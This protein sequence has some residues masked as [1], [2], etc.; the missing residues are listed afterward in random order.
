ME[1]K[2]SLFRPRSLL[3]LLLDTREFHS[4]LCLRW[5]QFERGADGDDGERRPSQI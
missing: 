4:K 5:F 1:T 3:A 2:V